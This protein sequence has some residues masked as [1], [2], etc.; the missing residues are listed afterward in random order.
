MWRLFGFSTCNRDLDEYTRTH[1][2]ASAQALTYFVLRVVD[3]K[4]VWKSYERKLVFAADHVGKSSRFSK[5]DAPNVF[6][7]PCSLFDGHQV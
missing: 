7:K 4:S 1:P 5:T 6:E 3:S 2:L